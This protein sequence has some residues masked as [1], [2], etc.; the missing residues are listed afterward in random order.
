[1]DQAACSSIRHNLNDEPIASR[2]SA[3]MPQFEEQSGNETQTKVKELFD[4]TD[5]EAP[6]NQLVI[7]S[8]LKDP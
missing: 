2:S 8:K 5:P 6:S 7:N 1:M 3:P 4:S